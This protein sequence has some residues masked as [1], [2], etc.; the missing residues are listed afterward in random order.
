MTV[1]WS[2]KRLSRPWDE[3]EWLHVVITR[4]VVQFEVCIVS[5]V[6]FASNLPSFLQALSESSRLTTSQR[7]VGKCATSPTAGMPSRVFSQATREDE[8][9]TASTSPSFQSA[10]P[11]LG[12]EKAIPEY[13]LQSKTGTQHRESQSIAAEE[14]DLSSST[15]AAHHQFEAST[16]P[17]PGA[18][19]LVS[20]SEN[21]QRP[22]SSPSTL[23]ASAAQ[24]SQQTTS[25]FARQPRASGL[26]ARS[27][28]IRRAPA[29]RSSHGIETL[30]GPPPALITQRSYTGD[31][32]WRYTNT[33]DLKEPIHQRPSINTRNTPSLAD[34][35]DLEQNS[36]EQSN[37]P[38]VDMASR[39]RARDRLPMEDDQGEATL[40]GT[41]FQQLDEARLQDQMGHDQFERQ[42]QSSHEDLFLNLARA[43]S[44]AGGDSDRPYSQQRRRVRNSQFSQGYE[45]FFDRGTLKS[46]FE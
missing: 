46:A 17:R 29:S 8:T 2:A 13:E 37:E 25:Y 45:S 41:D 36:L 14:I 28:S 31:N 23:Q 32:V 27:P 10:S 33:V 3:V 15:A 6:L 34:S 22:A 43:D 30:S 24:R 9:S 1:W 38:E 40:R 7:E 19:P 4:C 42:S 12:T 11:G 26:D 39:R 44:T 18:A 21:D 16:P 20:K 35:D 5:H